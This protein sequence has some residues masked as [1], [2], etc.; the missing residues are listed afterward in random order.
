ML[1]GGFNI[2]INQFVRV[3]FG[4]FQ[5]VVNAIGTVP[6]YFPYQARDDLTGLFAPSPGCQRLNG[7]DA[8]AY[9]RSRDL[10]YYSKSKRRWLPADAIP[11]INRISRQQQFIKQLPGIAAQRGLH[12][13]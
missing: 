3:G 7:A 4:S 9:V 10:Q 11:D 2:K 6:V 1:K 13:P 8:L 12:A 5:G